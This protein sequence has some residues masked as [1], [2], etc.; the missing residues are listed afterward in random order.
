MRKIKKAGRTASGTTWVSTSASSK[1]RGKAAAKGR[2]ITGHSTR[3]VRICLRKG[4][5]GGAG[6]WSGPSDPH[7]LI[8]NRGNPCLEETATA[9]CPLLSTYSLASWTTPGPWASRPLRCPTRLVRWP[10][11]TSVRWTSKGCQLPR[12]T[13]PIP[14]YRAWRCPAWWTLTT[15]WVTITTRHIRTMRSSWAQPPRHPRRSPPATERAFS[16]PAPVSPRSS[17]WCIAHTGNTKLNTRRYTRGL[18]FKYFHAALCVTRTSI[19]D[20]FVWFHNKFK[21]CDACL[22]AAHTVKPSWRY[23]HGD[24][25]TKTE[26]G[27]NAAIE[28]QQVAQHLEPFR[29]PALG[30]MTVILYCSHN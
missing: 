7:Q 21:H 15:A 22:G 9:T 20:N 23:D 1:C 30:L 13:T 3:P 17:R 28:T 25:F 18:I 10:A 26:P 2:G 14:G 5:T 24:N 16:L 11:V 6:G 4:T 29:A 8:S 27:G 12:L 19:K